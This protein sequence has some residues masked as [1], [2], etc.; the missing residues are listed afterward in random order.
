VAATAWLAHVGQR[1]RRRPHYTRGVVARCQAMV[2]STSIGEARSTRVGFDV[3]SGSPSYSTSGISS[4]GS[5]L[6]PTTV[7]TTC[8]AVRHTGGGTI[9]TPCSG[10]T[11]TV[12]STAWR[13]RHAAQSAPH[14]WRR[15]RCRRA[16]PRNASPP[17][18]SPRIV[19]S[20]AVPAVSSSRRAVPGLLW[21]RRA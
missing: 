17:C 1:V 2:A 8:P 16:A 11:A 20:C 13:L 21:R 5:T 18:A 15:G 12:P 19:H 14:P 7:G 6:A 4:L 3:P 10:S 9:L